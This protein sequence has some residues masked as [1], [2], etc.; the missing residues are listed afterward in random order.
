M[1]AN[2]ALTQG[3]DGA[4]V[5]TPFTGEVFALARGGIQFVVNEI[6]S[7]KGKWDTTGVLYL[8]NMRLVFVAKK[9][10]NATGL[11]AFALPLAYLR[12]DN[13]NQPIFGCNNLSGECWPAVDGGGPAGTLPPHR[14]KIYFKEGGVGTFLPLY[15]RFVAYIREIQKRQAMAPTGSAADAAYSSVDMNQAFIDPSDPSKVFLTQPVADKERIPAPVYSSQY[16]QP[17]P[18]Y[19]STGLRP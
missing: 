8:S 4:L 10:D 3:F 13:F 19:E 9:M 14:F 5:P 12:N 15:F 18:A 1:T 11:V 17:E 2:P 16:G 6:R 7:A